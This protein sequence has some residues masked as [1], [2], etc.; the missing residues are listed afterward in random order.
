[1]GHGIRGV[2]DVDALRAK[3]KQGDYVRIFD[4]PD[5]SPP[6]VAENDVPDYL[7]RFANRR[8]IEAPGKLPEEIAGDRTL[9][10]SLDAKFGSCIPAGYTYFGQFVDHDI[11]FDPS[12]LSMR[13]GDEN[14]LRNFR[15]SRLDLD[16]VYGRGPADQPYLYARDATDSFLI[17][18]VPDSKLRDLPRNDEGRALIGDMRNDANAIVSQLHL[19]FLLA[20]NALVVRARAARDPDPFESAR[21]TLRRLYQYIVW[22]DFLGRATEAAMHARALQLVSDAAGG[23]WQRGLA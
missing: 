16:S 1:M 20:H 10:D 3:I 23:S 11:T 5:W 4:L 19:A 12:P 14:E 21:R 7:L 17:G 2:I 15:T 22:H 8:M 6:G 18:R 9:N 13:R